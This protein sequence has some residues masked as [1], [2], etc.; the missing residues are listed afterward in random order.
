MA[1]QVLDAFLLGEDGKLK[2]EFEPSAQARAVLDT[3]AP[4]AAAAPTG[5]TIQ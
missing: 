2:P 1:R 5:A 3:D 4:A